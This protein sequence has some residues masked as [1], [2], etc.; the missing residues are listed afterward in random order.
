MLFRDGNGLILPGS[1]KV[2]SRLQSRFLYRIIAYVKKLIS[3]HFD[4]HFNFCF[5]HPSFHGINCTVNNW[6]NMAKN[7]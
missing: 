1:L 4:L 7:L 3:Q 2:D 6:G 5:R